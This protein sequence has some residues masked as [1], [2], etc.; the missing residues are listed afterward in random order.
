MAK[1]YSTGPA[2]LYAAFTGSPF[3]LG[4]CESAPDIELTG[5]FEPIFNDLAGSRLPMDRIWEGEEGLLNLIITRW[6]EVISR[7]LF[8]TLGG[9]IGLLT[10]AG[11]SLLGAIGTIMGQEGET[12]QMWVAFPFAAK[13]AYSDMPAGYHFHSCMAIGPKKITPGT[14]VNK[15]QLIMKAQRKL[16]ATAPA[17]LASN[18]FTLYDNDMTAVA[19]IPID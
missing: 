4:T 6:N 19:G 18:I 14:G 13:A 2:L 15:R 5:E 12:C 10:A 16:A 7:G 3:F 9:P 11:S 17:N 1:M 8:T